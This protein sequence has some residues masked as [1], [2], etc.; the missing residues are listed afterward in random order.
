MNTA[1]YTLD[2]THQG[3]R[4]DKALAMLV[5]DMS[6]SRLQQL[7]TQG[8]VQLDGTVMADA[9]KK[10]AAGE[11]YTLTVPPPLEAKPQPQ[12]IPLDIVFEDDDLLVINKPA[13]LTVHPGAG[14]PDK[15]MVNALLYHCGDSLSGVG[16]V[17]RP[18]IVH[19]IDKDTSGLI[20]VAKHDAAHRILSAQLEDRSLSRTYLA[21]VWGLPNPSNGTVEAAIGRDPK[22]RQRMMVV[23]ASTIRNAGDRDTPPAAEP[24]MTRQK[25]AASANHQESAE[26]TRKEGKEAV[27]HYQLT[28]AYGT[29]VSL[30]ECKLQTGRT[31]QIRVH[32]KHL[33]HPLIGDQTYG[34]RK[35]LQLRH[36]DEVMTHALKNFKRQALHARALAFIHPTSGE[37]MQFE[38]ELPADM[39]ELRDVMIRATR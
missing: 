31:H 30:V 8:H 6:R 1:T 16:G 4:L 39:A 11:V 20:I 17:A 37:P 34:S 2:E 28:E 38:C 15:T 12:N 26:L 21:M 29:L 7:I 5:E 33:G 10:V 32:M 14:N 35:S 25:F 24:I 9:K 36:H 3:L 27:T 13:G 18:G 19:R 22:N 23:Q